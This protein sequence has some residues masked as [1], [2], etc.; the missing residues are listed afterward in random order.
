MGVMI[1]VIAALQ[2]QPDPARADQPNDC[3]HAHVPVQDIECV[4][5]VLRQRLRQNG[6]KK[7]L[8]PVRSNGA[9]CVLRAGVGILNI[10]GLEFAEFNVASH[11][12]VGHV[13]QPSPFCPNITATADGTQVWFTLKD[14]G[15]TVAFNA[16]PPF[17]VLKVLDTG[18][19]TNHVNF[20]R[21]PD[22]QFAHVTV[23]GLNEVKVFRT[24]DFQQV[25]T[26]PVG[27][28]PHGVWPS[29]DGSHIYVGL[30][31]DDKLAAIDRRP[32]R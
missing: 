6:M 29:G 15:K 31:N 27:K 10:L 2:F 14:V 23:G 17:N 1:Q 9:Q 5:H 20:A 11:A 21:T 7:H 16:H 28:L 12:I 26:V 8:D 22:G 32:K 24:S 4:G 19:I 30:E 13:E 3:R 18:P 25:A